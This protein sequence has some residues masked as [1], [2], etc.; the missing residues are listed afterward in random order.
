MISMLNLAFDF[1][2][3]KI[4]QRTLLLLIP[5]IFVAYFGTL[6][7]AVRILD[8]SIG[9]TSRCQSCCICEPIQNCQRFT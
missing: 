4:R 7:F 6:T 9:V 1:F 3:G 2:C 5:L 8:P